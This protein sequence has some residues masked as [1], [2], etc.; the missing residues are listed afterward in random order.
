[1]LTNAFDTKFDTVIVCNAAKMEAI[2]MM[3]SL[4]MSIFFKKY[5]KNG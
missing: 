5:G 3:T 4:I 1:M 2:G